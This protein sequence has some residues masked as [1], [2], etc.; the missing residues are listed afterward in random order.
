MPIVIMLSVFY[1]EFHSIFLS[2]TM[3][4]VIMLSVTMLSVIMLSVIM[5]SI[6]IVKC[7][8]C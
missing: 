7:H 2:V 3:L 4:G 5:L 1:A 8:Y 6:I